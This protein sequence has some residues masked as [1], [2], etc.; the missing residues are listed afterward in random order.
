M[1]EYLGI[2]MHTSCLYYVQADDL[3][4]DFIFYLFIFLMMIY[5]Q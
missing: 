5:A 3:F 2:N 4:I 1:N